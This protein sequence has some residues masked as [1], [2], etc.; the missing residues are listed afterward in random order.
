M[1]NDQI[2]RGVASVLVLGAY[3]ARLRYIGNGTVGLFGFEVNTFALTLL[4]LLV[5]AV[6]ETLDRLPV[7]PT[8]K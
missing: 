1:R 4:V 7:G 8:R 6:P 5:L 3:L 2:I